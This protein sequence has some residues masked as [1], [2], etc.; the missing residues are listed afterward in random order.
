[1]HC[2]KRVGI[3][4]LVFV[5]LGEKLPK[6]VALNVRLAQRRFLTHD[7]ILLLDS[8]FL[9]QECLKEK[10]PAVL[11]QSPKSTWKPVRN[12]IGYS[13]KFRDDF[14]FRTV[15]RFDALRS[16]QKLQPSEAILHIEAD[17]L[18]T[19]TFPMDIF[20]RNN[21][22]SIAYPITNSDQG[23]ASTF[24]VKN[25]ESLEHFLDYCEQRFIENSEST[26]VSIL[27][28]YY[29]DF[30]EKCLVLPT[31]PS[32]DFEFNN[33]VNLSTKKIMSENFSLGNGIFDASTWGQFLTGHDPKNSVGVT[34]IF[35]NQDH[36][37]IRTNRINFRIDE[38]GRIFIVFDDQECEIFSLH[39]HSKNESLFDF[40][41][42]AHLLNQLSSQQNRGVIHRFNLELFFKLF[43][44]YIKYRTRLLVR[45]LIKRE[46]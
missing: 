18:L 15:A 23:V 46:K 5:Y 35:F 39:I 24:Y 32:I 36:H 9:Y 17:V 8:H 11:V 43:P 31:V 45:R 10:L 38:E 16:Y 28:T 40:D 30:P 19:P 3:L 6:Y 13:T 21:D 29:Q 7:V 2:A 42:S 37:A 34:P 1:M 20:E 26:D 44:G 33:H 4:K 22:F 25:L 27:G 41:K 12:S 14:W